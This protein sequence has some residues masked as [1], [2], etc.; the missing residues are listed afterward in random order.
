MATLSFEYI[1]QLMAQYWL[2]A[3]LFMVMSLVLSLVIVGWVIKTIP[4][5]YFVDKYSPKNLALTKNQLVNLMLILFKNLV[6][7]VCLLVGVVLLFL[8]GQGLLMLLV[9]VILVDFPAKYRL[10]RW[11]ICRPGVMKTINSLRRWMGKKA[12]RI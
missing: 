10:E 11:I 6:G 5:D 2:L 8:P 9:G 7:Y 1:E 4:E 12:L 3:S